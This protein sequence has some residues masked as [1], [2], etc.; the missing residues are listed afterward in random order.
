MTR[1]LVVL[2]L[3]LASGCG[4]GPGARYRA[5]STAASHET[6]AGRHAAAGERWLAAA[7]IAAS[8]NDRDEATYR[9]AAAFAR[10]GST[11]RAAELYV[12]LSR[13]SGNRAARASFDRARL[14]AKDDPA[15]GDALLVAATH[16]FPASGL[17]P[18]A[19]REHFASV[20]ARSGS[21][22][23]LAELERWL[24]SF[25]KTEL[26][27][28]L[29]Y[30]RGRRLERVGRLADARDA[31]LDGAWRHPYPRGALWNDA[32]RAAARLE[33]KLGR[34]REAIALLERLLAE[35]EHAWIVGSYERGYAEARFR[36]AVLERDA[37]GDAR[38]ARR[39]FRRVFDEFPTS[40]LR[41]DAL[42]EEARLA[43][44]GGDESGAC[45]AINLL[46]GTLP[47]SRYA[48]CAPELCAGARPRPG[49]RC[50]S[51]AA[52][53]GRAD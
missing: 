39:S 4:A 9:A 37:L 48:G 28:T 10:A 40:L 20:E 12:Q 53:Q 1:A 41:D 38:A 44:R 33:E 23:A 50:P 30:E 43:R 14:V 27:E 35:R 3:V 51:Y 16:R 17:A 49:R 15:R 45:E 22:A 5:E 31:Y 34:P 11:R 6:A 32:L 8:S 13:G 52:A 7:R 47:D 26:D 46:L 29:R 19:A 36:V 2:A 24:R 18:R 21:L 25:E 42:Y